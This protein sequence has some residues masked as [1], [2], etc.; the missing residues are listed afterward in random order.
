MVL[1][2]KPLVGTVAANV[3]TYGTGGLNIDGRGLVELME[4]IQL[5]EVVPL[6]ELKKPK[7]VAMVQAVG[8][9]IQVAVGPPMS[10]TMA[11]TRL[12]RCFLIRQVVVIGQKQK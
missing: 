10:S 7:V 9:K 12:W 1:A 6:L 5:R 4:M 2:R 11:V 3:L 8:N